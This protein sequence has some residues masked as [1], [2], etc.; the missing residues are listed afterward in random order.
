MNCE[1]K[2]KAKFFLSFLISC[3]RSDFSLLLVKVML[4]IFSKRKLGT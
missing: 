3:K 1:D 2:L 4:A